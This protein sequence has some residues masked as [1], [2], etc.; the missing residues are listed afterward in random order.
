MDLQKTIPANFFALAEQKANRPVLK[1]KQDGVYFSLSYKELAQEI[2]RV[3]S[4]L[5]VLGVKRRDRVAILSNGRP[6]WV[7]ADLAAMALGAISVPIHTTLS[8]KSINYIL[9]HCRAKILFVSDESLLNK[10]LIGQAGLAKPE[11]IIVMEKV[12]R[13]TID[14]CSGLCLSWDE[15]IASGTNPADDLSLPAVKSDDIAS[16]IYTSGT[17]GLPKGV[18]LSHGN[19]LSNVAAINDMVPVKKGDVFLSFLPLSHV[20]ERTAGYYTPLLFGATIAYGEGFK[21]LA[22]NL[23]E[24]R[25]T[26]M[27]AVP[28]VFEKFYDIIWDKVSSGSKIKKNIFHWALRQRQGS[29]GYKLG[30]L[31]VFKKIRA[32]LGGRLR[33]T[34]SGGASLD[35]KIAKF[36]QKLGILIVEGY[37]L[38]ETAPVVAVNRAHPVKFGTV[39][40]AV[41]GVE[42]KISGDK[43][44]LVKGPNVFRGYFNDQEATKEA[45]TDDGWFKTGDLGFIGRD[46]R[47]VIIGRKKEMMLTSGGK[48]IWPEALEQKINIDRFVAQ[49]MAI[50]HRRKF[51]SAL[52]VPDWQEV[53]I[54]LKEKGLPLGVPSKLANRPDILELFGQRL[55]KINQDLADY[56]RI[57]KFVLLTDEFSQERDELTPTLKLRRQV[58]EGHYQKEIEG[59]YV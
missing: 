3:V 16:I 43:E 38:T 34:V 19:F 4:A 41:D 26:V 50:A 32:Q 57:R 12:N 22:Q 5:N 48:N 6:E 47:L 18:A 39:G 21:Q 33:L 2:R 27:I 53:G 13:E 29:P 30:D 1:Y 23:K 25:P 36:F 59:M 42:I 35:P 40:Y 55:D 46:N 24:V 20:L 8:A 44:I 56:E 37:G 45:F 52:I 14:S 9:D 15:F 17:T 7:M 58:I 10:V 31:L 11:K 51:V 54:F 28:R 49:S